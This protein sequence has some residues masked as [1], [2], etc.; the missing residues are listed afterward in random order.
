[1][2]DDF[3][4]DVARRRLAQIEA[5]E[6]QAQA[7]LIA[8]RANGDT[9]YG[10]EQAEAL[11]VLALRK[12]ALLQMHQQHVASQNPPP[13]PQQTREQLRAKPIEQMDGNDAVQIWRT[14]KYGKD[15]DWNNPDVRA[16]WEFAKRNPQGR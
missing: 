11:E 15:L 12:Q 7:H 8:A 5:E 9:D 16:G 4:T 13:R 14:S 3:Y 1:M 10:T 6:A 2:S